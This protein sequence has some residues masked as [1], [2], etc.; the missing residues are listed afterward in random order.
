MA[1]ARGSFSVIAGGNVGRQ[2]LRKRESLEGGRGRVA[3]AVFQARAKPERPYLVKPAVQDAEGRVV[4]AGDGNR[5]AVGTYA[6]IEPDEQ[7]VLGNAWRHDIA[8]QIAERLPHRGP[9]IP[10]P[11]PKF[12]ARFFPV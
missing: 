2:P 9:R 12:S 10:M 11:E 1:A 8:G 5:G 3:R 6:R 7:P 4:V